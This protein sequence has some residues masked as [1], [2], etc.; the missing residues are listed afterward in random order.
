MSKPIATIVH[1]IGRNESSSHSYFLVA[2]NPAAQIASYCSITTLS[3]NSAYRHISDRSS[4][5]RNRLVAGVPIVPARLDGVGPAA[6][7]FH[8]PQ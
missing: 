2:V 8:F 3:V 4:A 1:N 5:A 6:V 7:G